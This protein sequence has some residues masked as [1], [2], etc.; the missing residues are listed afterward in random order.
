MRIAKANPCPFCAS[1]DGFTERGT[2]SSA[3]YMCNSCA[4]RGPDIDYDGEH[5]NAAGLRTR[6]QSALG[7]NASEGTRN[8]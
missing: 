1:E 5:G 3:Y 4:A 6:E 7:T 2:L 8:D